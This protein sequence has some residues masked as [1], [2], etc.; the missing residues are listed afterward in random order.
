MQQVCDITLFCAMGYLTR[1][2]PDIRE[3]WYGL[4]VQ[5]CNDGYS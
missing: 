5:E 4:R 2:T 1:W 3:S